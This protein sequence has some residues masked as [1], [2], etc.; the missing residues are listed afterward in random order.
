M[1]RV[2]GV[3]GEGADY[4]EVIGDLGDGGP[5]ICDLGGGGEGVGGGGMKVP[6]AEAHKNSSISRKLC[7]ALY[8]SSP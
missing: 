7:H 4:D 5:N 2:S 1:E 8:D 3:G 6:V